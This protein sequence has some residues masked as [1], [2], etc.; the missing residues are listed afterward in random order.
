VQTFQYKLVV[1]FASKK[2]L[3]LLKRNHF[4]AL[5]T[6]LHFSWQETWFFSHLLGWYLNTPITALSA[7][8]MYDLREEPLKGLTF[9]KV[10]HFMK[11]YQVQTFNMNLK[12]FLHQINISCFLGETILLLSFLF[13]FSIDRRTCSIHFL[14]GT[15]TGSSCCLKVHLHIQFCRAFSLLS[16]IWRSCGLY[17]KHI[18]I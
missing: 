9:L 13:L 10:W 2:Y 5:F 6:F 16:C 1:P 18:K 17:Y 11:F 14:G 7:L 15:K 4:M 3:T 12:L 8:Q